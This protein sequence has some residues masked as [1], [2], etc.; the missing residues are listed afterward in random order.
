MDARGVVMGVIAGRGSEFMLDGRYNKATVPK[1][2]T[3]N[4]INAQSNRL[5]TAHPQHNQKQ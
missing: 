5:N 3:A 1:D 2:K 4:P